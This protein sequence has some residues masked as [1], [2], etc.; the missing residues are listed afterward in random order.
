MFQAGE[1]NQNR[2]S[3]ANLN[4]STFNNTSSTVSQGVL[5]DQKPGNDDSVAMGEE[6]P[7]A[8]TVEILYINDKEFTLG[9]DEAYNQEIRALKKIAHQELSHGQWV[10]QLVTLGLIGVV[11]LMNLMIGS[12]K[13]ASIVGIKDCGVLYWG[14]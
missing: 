9:T 12:S 13:K 7:V 2:A 3:T 10:K 4:K 1:E 14:I 11:I 5:G 8:Q 6:S